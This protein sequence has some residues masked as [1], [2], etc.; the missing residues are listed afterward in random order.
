MKNSEFKPIKLH[1]STDLPHTARD[2]G[3]GWLGLV[4]FGFLFNNISTF[5][6]NLMPNPFL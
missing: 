6:G 5:M 2:E 1:L 4:W 3:V